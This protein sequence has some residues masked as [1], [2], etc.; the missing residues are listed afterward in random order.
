MWWFLLAASL[1]HSAPD[2]EL[3]RV[4]TGRVYLQ[5]VGCYSQHMPNVTF[6][7]ESDGRIAEATTNRKGFYQLRNLPAGAYKVTMQ[8]HKLVDA[9]QTGHIHIPARGC[10]HTE[11]SFSVYGPAEQMQEALFT[12]R[13]YLSAA[14][15]LFGEWIR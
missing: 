3:D 8:G 6:R 10:L 2:C 4:V 1:L 7:L 5:C 14:I 11:I 12:A 9:G 15:D 13:N